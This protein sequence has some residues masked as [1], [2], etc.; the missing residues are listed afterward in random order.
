MELAQG[1]G[2]DV[3]GVAQLL[4]PGDEQAVGHVDG[5]LVVGA[6]HGDGGH[7]LQL[8]A[9]QKGGKAADHRVVLLG[10]HPG[11]VGVIGLAPAHHALRHDPLGL[12]RVL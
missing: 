6:Q 4:V 11:S 3:E 5:G 9:V 12:L 7:L 2:L 8:Q 10:D 1:H